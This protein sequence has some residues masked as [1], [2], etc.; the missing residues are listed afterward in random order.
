MAKKIFE[1]SKMQK[2]TKSISWPVFG[3]CQG[4]EVIHFL[5]NKD[6]ADTLTNVKI[7]NEGRPLKWTVDEPK[8]DT[9]FFKDFPKSLL[10]KMSTE[11]L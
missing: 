2:D 8:Y 3:F 7:Y 4:F 10:D 5:V 11:K 1:Y 9:H 6:R